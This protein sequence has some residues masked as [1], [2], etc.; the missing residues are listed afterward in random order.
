LEKT[1][2]IRYE[3]DSLE[4]AK[5]WI[6][7][8]EVENKKQFLSGFESVR[9][10]CYKDIIQDFYYQEETNKIHYSHED[11]A[12][13]A[14]AYVQTEMTEDD[15]LQA[16]AKDKLVAIEYIMRN[17][18]VWRNWELRY[19]LKNICWDA[20]STINNHYL[21][22]ANMYNWTKEELI[23]KHPSWFKEDIDDEKVVTVE[24]GKDLIQEAN[25]HQSVELL[26]EI[27]STKQAVE[28]GGNSLKW[29]FYGI[30]ALV[31]IEF[32]MK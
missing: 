11:I 10:A 29:I 6:Q 15:I 5:R 12:Y 9:F 8:E 3:F 13:R 16:Y 25:H 4:V 7:T 21:D 28:R 26:R 18:F 14:C 19:V 20:D 30:L 22:C 32:F 24:A 31:L 2:D 1:H 27:L 23:K 17:M